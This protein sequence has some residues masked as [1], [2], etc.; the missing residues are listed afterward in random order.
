MSPGPRPPSFPLRDP[1]GRIVG[2]FGISRD[3][4]ARKVA[5]QRLQ[6]AQRDLVASARQQP[7]PSSPNVLAEALGLLENAR[8]KTERIRRRATRTSADA[9]GQLAG[10]LTTQLGNGTA[11]HQLAVNLCA[12]S[13]TAATEQKALVEDLDE[14]QRTLKQLTGLLSEPKS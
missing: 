5:E 1:A 11:E 4:T 8:I 6:N 7:S 2:T 3:V 14:L 12:L 10:Q 9:M 13:N